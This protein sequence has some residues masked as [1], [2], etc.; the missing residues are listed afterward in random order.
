MARIE[1]M[2]FLLPMHIG[3][4]AELEAEI[5]FTAPH[6]LLVLVTVWAE[7][8]LSGIA[9]CYCHHSNIM[10]HQCFMMWYR[11]NGFL[12]FSGK[13]R[14]TNKAHLWYVPVG[15]T[16]HSKIGDVPP[17]KY[18]SPLAEEKGRRLYEKQKAERQTNGQSKELVDFQIPSKPFGEAKNQSLY[19]L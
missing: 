9:C 14:L 11:H 15:V 12:V 4:V 10:N 5:Y 6:S 17:M 8:V 16:D 19:F 3:E 2:D 13:K 1:H 18:S 7:N